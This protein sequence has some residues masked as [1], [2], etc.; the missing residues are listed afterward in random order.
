M[1][2]TEGTEEATFRRALDAEFERLKRAG[3]PCC[4]YREPDF[5]DALTAVATA[6]L[7][8]GQRT[9]LRELRLLR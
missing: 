6:P 5:G 7:R 4:A 3:I 8:G 9:A 2:T 1:T